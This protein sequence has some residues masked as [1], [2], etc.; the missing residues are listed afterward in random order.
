MPTV[1]VLEEGQQIREKLDYKVG[2]IVELEIGDVI[3]TI[4]P[5]VLP[6]K[7]KAYTEKEDIVFASWSLGVKG[8]LSREEIYDYL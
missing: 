7:E 2:D 3:V 6:G 8:E 4:R 5:R 1:R